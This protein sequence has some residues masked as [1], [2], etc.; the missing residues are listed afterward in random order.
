LARIVAITLRSA[1]EPPGVF[2]TSALTRSGWSIA[3]RA[4]TQ[5]AERDAGDR[6]PL[7]LERVE[8]GDHVVD[9]VG[10][11]ERV[12]GEIAP[13]VADQVERQ[14]A[15][16]SARGGE[17]A[18]VALEVAAGAIARRAAPARPQVRRRDSGSRPPP[19]SI[20]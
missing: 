12:V 6:D 15:A 5:P 11:L 7:D 20:Q 3:R 10:D 1:R 4:A 9:V 18:R 16:V 17:I 19:A 14:H 13:T 8:E 2:R